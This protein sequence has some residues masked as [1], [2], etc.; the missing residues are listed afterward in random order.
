MGKLL[1]CVN[2]EINIIVCGKKKELLMNTWMVSPFQP[3][4]MGKK[5]ITLRDPRAVIAPTRSSAIIINADLIMAQMHPSTFVCWPRNTNSKQPFV[6]YIIVWFNC[7][8]VCSFSPINSGRFQWKNENCA[9]THFGS[10][11]CCHPCS[12]LWIIMEVIMVKNMQYVTGWS[13]LFSWM[14]DADRRKC[15]DEDEIWISNSIAR[16]WKFSRFSSRAPCPLWSESNDD[17]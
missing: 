2:I 11:V 17:D 7:C 4:G 3:D 16:W 5:L 10:I 6:A 14:L 1:L 15:R 8:V 12:L 13:L 9:V